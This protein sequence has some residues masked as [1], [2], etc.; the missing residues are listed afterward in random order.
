MAHK[1]LIMPRKGRA[2]KGPRYQPPI[3]TFRVRI[4]PSFYAP[5]DCRNI[6][7]E[8]EI[9]ANQTIYDLGEA[10]PLAFDFDDPHLW[11]FFLSGKAWDETTE[12]A[13]DMSPDLF[14]DR[15]AHSARGTRIRDVPLP[16]KTGKK[17]FL[18][19]FDFG[20][21]WEFGVKFLRTSDTIDPEAVYP[22]V[23]ARQGESPPQ[24][25][26]VEEED[27][28][29]D[30]EDEQTWQAAIESAPPELRDLLRQA[31]RKRDER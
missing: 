17:E 19:L 31:S 29:W 15:P 28:E 24:Y 5:P 12:Y 11:S 22:R 16:G 23:V 26:D 4:L 1:R 6:R 7:R 3:Y 21:Q 2:A 13:M 18:F 8:I 9:A 30:E 20:D 25:P 27:E 14:G 10:I